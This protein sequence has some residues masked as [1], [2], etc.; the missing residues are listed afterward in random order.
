MKKVHDEKYL[1]RH[2]Q[3]GV[4]LI[5]V[6]VSI[7]LISI[8]GAGLA[9]NTIVSYRA[10]K[11]IEVGNAAHN[12]AIQKIE[13]FAGID[14]VDLDDADDL[15]ENSVVYSGLSMTFTRVTNV[16]VNANNTRQVDVT[17]TCN[18]TLFD[19]PVNYRAT[20]SVWE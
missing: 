15:T 20:F 9:M 5:E 16:T 3:R 6:L 14:A 8:L 19:T 13:E 18:N 1:T 2:S 11:I 10:N 7:S 12:L 17:V 4:G